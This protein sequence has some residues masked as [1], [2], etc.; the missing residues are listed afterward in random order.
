MWIVWWIE[1]LGFWR[2]WRLESCKL[3]DRWTHRIGRRCPNQVSTL[4]IDEAAIKMIFRSFETNLIFIIDSGTSVYLYNEINVLI[5]KVSLW[6]SDDR[7]VLWWI[8]DGTI[9]LAWQY[10]D[11][12][13]TGF[14]TLE[15]KDYKVSFEWNHVGKAFWIEHGCTYLGGSVWWFVKWIVFL[16]NGLNGLNGWKDLI[17]SQ[18][19]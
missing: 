17:W 2:I 10:V 18:F 8:D 19:K 3:L 9:G 12:D 13:W 4:I 15:V 6:I 1:I 14:F 5:K 16:K 7:A 11:A